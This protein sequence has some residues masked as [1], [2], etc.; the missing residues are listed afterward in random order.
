MILLAGCSGLAN[1]PVII[2][3][4]AVATV[5][6]TPPPDRGVPPE[7]VSLIRG[8]AIYGGAQGCQNCHGTSGKGD[9]PTASSLTCKVPD[10]SNPATSRGDTLT[11]WFAITTNG[12]GQ[13]Q[14]CLMPPWKSRLNEQQRWDVTA[15][16]Y[17]IHYTPDQLIAGKQLYTENCAACHGDK[18]MGDGPKAKDSA[19]P[20][21]KLANSQ[22]MITHSDQ[23]MFDAV[24]NG[25]GA[26]MPA[27]P[28]LTEAQRW[29]VVAYARSLSWLDVQAPNAVNRVILTDDKNVIR[30]E[31]FEMRFEF[32]GSTLKVQQG[33]SLTNADAQRTF[34]NRDGGSVWIPLPT[35]ATNVFLDAQMRSKFTVQTGA[36]PGISGT[37]PFAPGETQLLLV[38]FDL[39][40][41]I[42]Y[43]F[44]Q[45]IAYDVGQASILL[46]E[47]A[48]IGIVERDFALSRIIPDQA[49]DGKP[50]NYQQ[51][52]PSN[53]LL[54][55][56]PF[57]FT[58]EQQSKL[59]AQEFSERRNILAAVIALSM[60]AFAVVIL[61]VWRIGRQLRA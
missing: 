53:T 25:V 44:A 54:G 6:P 42:P 48:G 18:G 58:L 22:F 17:S 60:A 51:Y 56:L 35:G 45:T 12:N 32:A 15:F 55:G 61:G 5:T 26:I 23:A 50:A 39:P 16:M 38:E 27:F 4:Q 34:Q 10:V 47:S 43:T 14:G 30:L 24:T 28:N 37:K 59:N 57:K 21:T 8:A 52:T 31:Q 13:T 2:R 40:L 7:P 9:G 33:F 19:R 20:V 49:P 1:E 41:T 29:S 3:T 36:N 46:P 11:R